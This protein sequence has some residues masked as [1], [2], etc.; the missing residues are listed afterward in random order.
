MSW[1]RLLALEGGTVG[2]IACATDPTGTAFAATLTGVHRTSSGADSWEWV[3]RGLISPFVQDVAVSP[4]FE[5]DGVVVAATAVSGLHLSFDRGESWIRREFWGIRP[6]VTRVAISPG[7]DRDQ[8]LVAGTQHEGVFV[9]GNRGR[10]WN[11]FASGLG[12]TEISALAI[13]PG[14]TDGGP[15][16]AAAEDGALLRSTDVGRTWSRVERSDP[17]PLECCAWV[18]SHTAIA[19]TVSGRLLRSTDG[20]QHWDAVWAV[21]ADTINGVAV[22]RAQGGGRLVAAVTGGGR[23]VLSTDDG[24]TWHDTSAVPSG[25]AAPLCVAISDGRVLIGTDRGGVYRGTGS[26]SLAAFNGG[27]VNRPI[28]DLAASPAFAEDKTLL[29]GTLQDGVLISRDG[30]E[31][32]TSALDEPGLGPVTA[33]RLSPAVASDGVSGGI[34]GGQVVWSDD[35]A[36]SWVRLGDLTTDSAANVLEFSPD[37][38]TDGQAVVG[39]EDGML[40]LSADRGDSWRAVWTGIDSSDVLALAYSPNFAQDRAMVAA[41]G[42]AHRLVVIRSSDVGETWEPWVEYDTALG[43]ASL[44][45]PPT[46]RPDVGPLLLAARD[47]I[48]TPPTSGRGPWSG[49]QVAEGGVAIRQITISPDFERDGLAAAAT[50]DGPYLSDSQGFEWSRMDGPLAG[51]A[52]ERVS[53]SGAD[54]ERR[55][56]HAALGRGELWRFTS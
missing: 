43:W 4:N 56:I 25:D 27:L 5:R 52:V 55:T 42:D 1:E 9:S 21:D 10:S 50:S 39:G 17:D 7:F 54:T 53:I 33:I 36:R 14:I 44:A 30:G 18:D 13:A 3:G 40:Y 29:L 32:W 35:G 20:G 15:I 45:I 23:L 24:Q 6:T 51:E 26:S 16:L 2:A 8:V 41:L 12:D 48:A 22:G 47:R 37:F 46:F 19:G 11:G 28:L 38:G 34:A 49:V 31:S